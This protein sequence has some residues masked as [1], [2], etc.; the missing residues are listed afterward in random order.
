M[1]I[2]EIGVIFLLSV[3]IASAIADCMPNPEEDRDL[4]NGLLFRLTLLTPFLLLINA[5]STFMNKNNPTVRCFNSIPFYHEGYSSELCNLRGVCGWDCEFNYDQA[6]R[7]LR[8]GQY[9]PGFKSS[10]LAEKNIT[11][12]KKNCEKVWYNCGCDWRWQEVLLLIFGLII[13]VESCALV[14]LC[15]IRRRSF[16]GK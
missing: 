16:G 1:K 9:P 10:E 8:S 11:A 6:L 12:V 15:V 14:A 7:H 4:L 2:T 5:S 3:F 13:L